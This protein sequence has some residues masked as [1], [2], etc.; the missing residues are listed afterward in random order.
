MTTLELP[1]QLQRYLENLPSKPYCSDTI[2]SESAALLIRSKLTALRYPHIQHNKPTSVAY[3]VLDLDHPQVFTMLQNQL[4]PEPSF[5]VVNEES[6]HAHVFYELKTPVHKTS[7]A[8][9]K[10]LRYLASIEHALKELWEAD[11]AYSGLISKNPTSDAWRLELRRTEPWEL[12]ELADWLTLPAKL[13]RKS[14]NVGLGRNCT[15]FD[16]LRFWAYEHVLDYRLQGGHENWFKAVSSIAESFN[17]FPEPLPINEVASTAKSVA[18][19]T[20]TNY[21]KRMSDD[22]FSARQSAR[23][24]RGGKAGGRGRTEADKE[25]RLQAAQMRAEGQTQQEIA[26]ELGVNKSTVCRWLK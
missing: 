3:I 14:Q 6:W 24:K 22:E 11:R 21:T 9:M 7:V 15:L 1:E 4:I 13:P 19:W 26:D 17:T 8:R 16:M 5:I 23:G 10:P 2:K 20:W 12:G 25:K 18:K